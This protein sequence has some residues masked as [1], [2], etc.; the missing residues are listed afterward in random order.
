ML[1]YYISSVPLP[2]VHVEWCMRLSDNKLLYGD[3]LLGHD[4]VTQKINTGFLKKHLLALY[5]IT[6]RQCE[7][8]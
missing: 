1:Q 8:P 2:N 4:R 6:L 5:R 7:V 3:M